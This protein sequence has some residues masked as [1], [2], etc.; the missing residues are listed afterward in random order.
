MVE[1][2]PHCAK[3]GGVSR[4]RTLYLFAQAAL[5][6]EIFPCRPLKIEG[7]DMTAAG[8]SEDKANGFP[9]RSPVQQAFAH[10]DAIVDMFV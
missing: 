7:A 1:E 8:L 3:A 4:R 10:F 5:A 2:Q 9:D 6:R